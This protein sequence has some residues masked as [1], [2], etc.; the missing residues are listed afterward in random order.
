[1]PRRSRG[2]PARVLAALPPRCT[3]PRPPP[4][5]GVRGRRG[6]ARGP[7]GPAFARTRSG[8][9][10]E[11]PAGPGVPLATCLTDSNYFPLLPKKSHD[12]PSLF[13][14]GLIFQ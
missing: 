12:R 4:A 14:T 8:A 1:M 10:E 11:R 5:P 9:R 2:V 13:N 7:A 6:P 3:C